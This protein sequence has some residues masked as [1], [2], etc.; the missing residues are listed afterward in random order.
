[1][2]RVTGEQRLW[3]QSVAFGPEG[4][5]VLLS[6][7]DL[8][9]ESADA[10]QFTSVRL[11]AWTPEGA[12]RWSRRAEGYAPDEYDW[13][14]ELRSTSSGVLVVDN[15][16]L[17]GSVA[18]G[19]DLGCGKLAHN[20][21]IRLDAEGRCI[22]QVELDG[23]IT[24]LALDDVEQAYVAQQVRTQ[25]LPYQRLDA[26]GQRVAERASATWESDLLWLSW[27]PVGGLMGLRAQGRNGNEL[28]WLSPEFEP[29]RRRELPKAILT[30]LAV[31]SNGRMVV[32]AHPFEE[33]LRWGEREIP[34]GTRDAVLVIEP[35]GAPGAAILLAS[36]YDG[37]LRVAADEHGLVIAGLATSWSAEGPKTHSMELLAYGWDGTLQGRQVVAEVTTRT[38][39]ADTYWKDSSCRATLQLS[40]L[41]LHP[42][43]GIRVAG[44]VQGPAKLTAAGEVVADGESQS[45]VMAFRR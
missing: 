42:R 18:T 25:A 32:R 35:D 11:D 28:V 19:V 34:A 27:N 10:R 39:D 6:L 8:P 17:V 22:N 31:S 44:G 5:T 1:M 38:C 24:A 30:P 40:N 3:G 21:L 7:F 12:P 15:P 13:A 2:R 9:R 29:L 26:N 16:V 43:H 14:Y 23:E 41:A 20:R 36:S 37:S 4:S 33:A 45:F